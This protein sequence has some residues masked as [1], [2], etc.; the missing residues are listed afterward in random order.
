MDNLLDFRIRKF[1]SLAMYL[2]L[3]GFLDLI[4]FGSILDL[5]KILFFI[6]TD[7]CYLALLIISQIFYT[8]TSFIFA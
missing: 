8:S 7:F 5:V 3:G 1:K 4:Y 6:V 2:T